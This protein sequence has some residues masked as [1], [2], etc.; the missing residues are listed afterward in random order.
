MIR[1]GATNAPAA[2]DELCDE[3]A[4]LEAV[5]RAAPAA[6]GPAFAAGSFHYTLPI[7]FV[8][9]SRTLPFRNAVYTSELTSRPYSLHAVHLGITRA[10]DFFLHEGRVGDRLLQALAA[11][12]AVI[13]DDGGTTWTAARWSGAIPGAL[14][15]VLFCGPSEANEIMLELGPDTDIAAWDERSSRYGAPLSPTSRLLKADEVR[16]RVEQTLEP[17]ALGIDVL[18]HMGFERIF[19]HGMPPARWAER[20]RRAYPHVSWLETSHP[21]A[22]PK[23]W[24][25]FD[26]VLRS[27]A[28]RTSARVVC[29]PLDAEG[30][31]RPEATSDDVHYTPEGAREVARCVVSFVEG[32]V[33]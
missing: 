17:F 8:G 18:R 32:A 21:N 5:S 16:Q 22:F 30:I 3:D 29:G 4:V 20:F 9:D 10:V 33:E 27:I 26:E 6:A 31:L 2:A 13:T 23:V 24:L 1:S 19:V 7:C 11:D 28:E 15:L 14:P 12:R 25:L